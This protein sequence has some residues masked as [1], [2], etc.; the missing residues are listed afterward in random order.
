MFYRIFNKNDTS[1][2]RFRQA[3]VRECGG[4]I[5][6][7]TTNYTYDGLSRK[8]GRNQN[9]E[10]MYR[11]TNFKWNSTNFDH[12]DTY[13]VNDDDISCISGAIITKGWIKG[14]IFHYNLREFSTHNRTIF[15]RDGGMLDRLVDYAVMRDL[16][17]V[18]IS[19]FPHEPKLQALCKRLREGRSIPTTGNLEKIRSMKYVGTYMYNGVDQDFFALPIR[20]ACFSFEAIKSI[21]GSR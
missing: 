17:G 11:Y 19:I 8:Y 13:W 15:F 4:D 3:V 16:L 18:Y 10:N 14:A 12:I 9:T 5:E 7:A 6:D 21:G 1:L 2:L 20:D